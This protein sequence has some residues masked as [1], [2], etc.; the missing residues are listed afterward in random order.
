M[1]FPG[2]AIGSF[3][4]TMAAN[5]AGPTLLN[6]G[7]LHL[8]YFASFLGVLFLTGCLILFFSENVSYKTMGLSIIGG[9]AMIAAQHSR[10]QLLKKEYTLEIDLLFQLTLVF[11]IPTLYFIAGAKG[12]MAFY[13]IGSIVAL[14]FYKG[15]N[16]MQNTNK[17]WQLR[18]SGLVI[19]G[20]I[21][22]LFFQLN[23]HIYNK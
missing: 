1:L 11:S 6:K 9:A 23:G 13:L 3:L 20:L 2:F 15:S 21:F 14:L 4:G 7:L 16:V 12:L 17:K 8:R 22:P 18:L 10:L 19:L 5:V